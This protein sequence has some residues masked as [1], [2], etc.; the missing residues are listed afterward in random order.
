MN[1]VEKARELRRRYKAAVLAA[2]TLI[3][4]DELTE[5]EL[6]DIVDLY[7]SYQAGRAYEKGDVFRYSGKLFRVI[8]AHTSQ[9][10][11]PPDQTPALYAHLVPEGVIGEWV[12]P[13]GQ[14][15]AYNTGD[16]VIHDGQVW[17]SNIDGNVWAPGVHGWSLDG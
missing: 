2:R 17:V 13:L 11:W 5:T 8:S 15:D 1:K 7:E 10:D 14:H 6:A 3:R 16:R 4:V 12:Q 9:A